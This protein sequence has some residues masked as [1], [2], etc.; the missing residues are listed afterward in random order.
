MNILADFHHSDLYYS[1][2]LVFE[3][4]LDYNLYRPIGMDWF[5][6]GFWKL[7]EPYG[8]KEGTIMQFLGRNHKPDDK[9]PP[10]N[11]EYVDFENNGTHYLQ[12][13]TS[14]MPH[15]AITL[16]QFKEMKIDALIATVP[17]Q[18]KPFNEL[19]KQFK[20]EAKLIHQMGNNW[21]KTLN[22]G[23]VH[24]LMSSTQP[25]KIPSGTNVVWYRQ[26]FDTSTFN[27]TSLGQPN[28]IYSFL[29]CLK[30]TKDSDLFYE[31]KETM[32]DWEFKS[33]GGQCDDGTLYPHSVLAKEMKKCQFV[34]QMKHTGDG[35]GH[36]IHNAYACGRPVIT[37]ISY[38]KGM[39]AEPFLEHGKTCID[40]DQYKDTEEIINAINY[41]SKPSKYIKM[42]KE[43]AQRFKEQVNF[44]EEAEKIKAF[45]KEL[46]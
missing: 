4:R 18:I 38:Y 12:S 34:W 35:Y 21:M 25:M 23:M 17:Q 28:K 22:F 31:L 29:N 13:H 24:N 5:K 44:D 6:Q 46:K 27:Y 3:K 19:R 37:R 14:L 2:Q 45:I 10:L 33:Y 26:E 36:I 20:P 41:Y 15:K 40:L 8:N 1:M 39:L 32:G 9:T 43:A 16:D 7:A 11:D 30:E 42:S